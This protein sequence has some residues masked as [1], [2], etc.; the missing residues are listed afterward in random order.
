M[1]T[2]YCPD[3]KT[4]KER[5]EGWWNRQDIGRPL[6]RV[7]AAGRNGDVKEVPKPARLSDLYLDPRY[8]VDTYRNYCESHYFLADA[9]PNISAD[10]GPGSV[11]LYLGGEPD[12]GQD[13]VWFKEMLEDA[14]EL[15]QL[16]YDD[17]NKWWVQ[18]KKL[19]S[20]VKALSKG[21]F[22]V[23]IPD[24]MENIDILAAL[25]GPQEMCFD[26]IDYPEEVED[27]IKF[28]D[29]VYF[30]YYDV[31][32]DMVRE[33]D[34]TVSFTAF[35]IL[36]RDRIA[37]VQCDFSALI[38][39]GMFRELIQP[40]LRKQCQNLTHS[41]YHLDGPDAIKHVEA[42]MEIGELDALQWTCGAGQPDGGSE[43]WYTIYDKVRAAGKSL[44][45]QIYDGGVEDW[46]KSTRRL[47]DRYGRSG[48]YFIYPDFPDRAT[49][50]DFIARF[51]R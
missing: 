2:R 13:T 35:S 36:G 1:N 3:Y 28:I 25:R 4:V 26:M 37:K 21:D 40:S 8:L 23:N 10:L 33:P 39:P 16:R 15:K 43:R 9:Y 7:V 31:F 34:G 50:E 42:L 51:E 41:L 48:M 29:S 46:A 11:A 5:F 47:M 27:A 18:H 6:M 49:A 14:E 38:S 20:D 45:I 17:A 44:W 12:F 32:R 30:R 24:L 22:I 19:L